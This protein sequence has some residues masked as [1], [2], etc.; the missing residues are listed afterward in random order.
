MVALE[1]TTH[2]VGDMDGE[3]IVLANNISTFVSEDVATLAD[4]F[5]IPEDCAHLPLPLFG[6]FPSD[7]LPSDQHCSNV[8]PGLPHL[9]LVQQTSNF[10]ALDFDEF[11]FP[12]FRL[13]CIGKH[14]GKGWV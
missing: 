1:S 5:G 14:C 6:F 2:S 9:G 10:T 7:P 12:V 11:D 3:F 8:W 13:A 4:S